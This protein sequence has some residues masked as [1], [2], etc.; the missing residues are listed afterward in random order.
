MSWGPK[1]SDKACPEEGSGNWG[2]E[3]GSVGGSRRSYFKADLYPLPKDP[4][5]RGS[6]DLRVLDVET[7]GQG[8]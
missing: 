4:Q 6:Q 1:S 5:G 2:G 7:K 8:R 3:G